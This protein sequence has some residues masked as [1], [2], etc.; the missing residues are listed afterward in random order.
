MSTFGIPFEDRIELA[1]A[2]SGWGELAIGRELRA[3]FPGAAIAMATDAKAAA[4]A[5]ARWGALAGCDP[6]LYLNL[7]TGLSAALVIGGQVVGG[8]NGAAGEIGYNLRA[9]SDVARVLQARVMLEDRVS[10]RAV[11]ERAGRPM[12]AAEVFAASSAD[13]ALDHLVS[14]FITELAFHLVN[15]A[16]FVNPVKIAVGGGLVGS[17]DR[18]APGLAR[19]LRPAPRSRPSWRQAGSRPTPR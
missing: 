6:A 17:W 13:P 19:A 3:A 8:A 1:P 4:L 11:G 7:G 14:E 10:G 12:T 18:L 2:I 9:V 5:E 15:L 16:I